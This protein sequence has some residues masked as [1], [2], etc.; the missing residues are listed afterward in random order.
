MYTVCSRARYLNGATCVVLNGLIVMPLR[1]LNSATSSPLGDFV[2]SFEN[3]WLSM[4]GVMAVEG[5]KEASIIYW[6]KLLTSQAGVPLQLKKSTSYSME[7]FCRNV[8]GSIFPPESKENGVRVKA[9]ATV[10]EKSSLAVQVRSLFGIGSVLMLNVSSL[11]MKDPKTQ[12]AGQFL[13]WV[14]IGYAFFSEQRSSRITPMLEEARKAGHIARN[15]PPPPITLESDGDMV[16]LE[17]PIHDIDPDVFSD[18]DSVMVELEND[19]I[20]GLLIE[21]VN[22]EREPLA[23]QEI[24]E[25]ALMVPE[26]AAVTR[27]ASSEE[28][29]TDNSPIAQASNVDEDLGSDLPQDDG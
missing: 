2:A 9:D 12:T 22:E 26:N 3:Y 27:S 7:Q 17:A 10:G 13:A 1:V 25:A 18:N 23:G 5:I 28:D 19:H 24:D 8:Q 29:N 16:E 11:L 20:G 6:Q 21:E 14:T 15:V 4:S